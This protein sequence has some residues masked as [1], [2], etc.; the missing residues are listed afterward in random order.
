MKW[1]G[2]L[3]L[4][5]GTWAITLI[6]KKL[7]VSAN[8]E[9]WAVLPLNTWST[10]VCS[11]ELYQAIRI[12]SI[13]S[14][15][16]VGATQTPTGSTTGQRMVCIHPAGHSAAGGGQDLLLNTVTWE[17]LQE[18]CWVKTSHVNTTCTGFH[19][20]K[21]Q[22]PAELTSHVWYWSK[23]LWWFQWGM[24]RVQRYCFKSWFGCWLYE[25]LW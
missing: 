2:P 11:H 8:G 13:S 23:S 3:A 25:Y 5:I 16:F 14:S 22:E 19:L 15:L 1:L 4:L 20:T 12:S 9:S 7:P 17:F 6:L 24:G 10:E 21:T 18:E